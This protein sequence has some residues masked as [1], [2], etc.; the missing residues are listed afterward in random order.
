M[1]PAKWVEMPPVVRPKPLVWTE[2]RIEQ[3]KRSGKLPGPVMVWT[4]EQTGQFLDHV[5]HHRLYPLFLLVAHRG[6]RRGEACGARWP[7][8]NLDAR[9]YVCAES[10]RAVRLGDRHVPA[11]DHPPRKGWLPW[12]PI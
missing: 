8:T 9:A 6:L 1:N 11:E 3:W 12:M 7:D 5:V 10:D 4:P 2:E